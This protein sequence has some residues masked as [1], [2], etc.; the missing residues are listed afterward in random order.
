MTNRLLIL[1]AGLAGYGVTQTSTCVVVE[2]D[3]IVAG[4][5]ASR[6]PAFRAIPPEA[7]VAFAPAPGAVRIF[8]PFE[9]ASLARRYSV[10][11]DPSTGICFER[12]LEPLDRARALEAMR[13]AL[14]RPDAR[15]EIVETSLYKVPP[16]KISFRMEGLRRPPSAGSPA[17]W[18]GDVIYGENRRFAIWARVLI[19]VS[20]SRLVAIDNLKPGER[21]TASQVRVDTVE[22][23]PSGSGL[24]RSFDEIGERVP[25]RAIAQGSEIQLAWLRVPADIARGETVEVEVHSGSARLSFPAVADAGGHA[26]DLITLRNPSSGKHFKARVNGKGKALVEAA[27]TGN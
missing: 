10:E 7:P 27:T 17:E 3:R 25:W 11:M 18:R 22:G 6:F 19:S 20:S 16:G 26:G 24:A 5:M 23:F 13:T 12:R 1:I 14:A 21:I 2:A 4:D 15:I 8:K 9:L